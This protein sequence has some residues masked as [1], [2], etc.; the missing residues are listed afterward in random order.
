MTKPLS[1]PNLVLVGPMGAGKSTVGRL[2]ADWLGWS[3]VDVDK[4]I[5]QQSQRT[6]NDLFADAGEA[7]FRQLEHKALCYLASRKRQVISTGGGIVLRRDNWEV[8]HECGWIVALLAPP[9]ELARRVWWE[10]DHRP[11][12]R[13]T[14]SE[15]DLEAR[16]RA[17]LE[18]R[19]PLY[20]QANTVLQTEGRML[21]DIAEEIFKLPVV[22]HLF[23]E[24]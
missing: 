7:Y 2:V 24:K 23:L 17:I 5:E 19:L 22:Q 12:L 13:G 6:I 4:L 3:F 18:Q 11:L 16:V 21:E 8:M 14:Q 20:R 15:A 1:I 9:E 10:R